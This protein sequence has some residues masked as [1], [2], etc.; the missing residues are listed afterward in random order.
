MS[1]KAP[2]KASLTSTL[3]VKSDGDRRV[4]ESAPPP[5]GGKSGFG[6][7][8]SAQYTS[9]LA[10]SGSAR[11]S[12]VE[13]SAGVS[14]QLRWA[15]VSQRGY[16]PDTPNK[17]CVSPRPKRWARSASHAV[18]DATPLCW[19]SHR[20]AQ[21]NQDALCALPAFGNNPQDCLFGVF[22]GHGEKGAQ[23]AQLAADKVCTGAPPLNCLGS[24]PRPQDRHAHCAKCCG[25]GTT[26]VGRAR[27]VWTLG[28]A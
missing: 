16:Y 21:D 2:L 15:Y 24:P 25:L 11:E 18:A 7:L 6:P 10:H 8:S 17:V 1:N 20:S 23:C 4:A 22:D 27:A 9:R 13:L 14:Y 5:G 19:G 28:L 3:R 12:T 26:L